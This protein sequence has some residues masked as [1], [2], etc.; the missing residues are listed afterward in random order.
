MANAKNLYLTIEKAEY[1]NNVI[2]ELSDDKSEVEESYLKVRSECFDLILRME[3]AEVK[4]L[5]AEE[6]LKI[7]K[8][9]NQSEL[10]DKI[11]EVSEK[12]KT[13]RL[14]AMRAE[15][16]SNELNERNNYLGRQVKYY[17]DSVKKL[18]EQVSEFESRMHKRDEEFR[19]ADNER[20]RRFF[21]ARF[22]D[23]GSAFQK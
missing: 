7:L 10:S 22:D 19:R 14:Q 17:C 16:Q 3:Q 23:V 5:S 2:S 9:S 15:R 13:F 8:D 11:I 1:F 4:A 21:N 6:M 12:I 18:E 20:M